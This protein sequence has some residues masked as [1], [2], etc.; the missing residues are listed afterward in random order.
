[1]SSNLLAQDNSVLL[2]IDV[3]SKL[4]GAMSPE[5]RQAVTCYSAILAEAANLLNIPVLV[6]EQYPKGLGTTD[7][8]ITAKLPQTA[9]T[10]TKT[11]FS[12]C[13]AIGFKQALSSGQRQQIILT[14]MEA[15]ICV[16]QTALDLHQQGYQISVV[17][18]PYVLAIQN[19][20][21][22]PCNAYNTKA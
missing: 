13:Q 15:H 3:Q 22:M 4:L 7:S 11:S 12:C 17:A 1:M 10:F 8:V 20:N 9:E 6:T 14:G 18:E 16:L 19:I 5:Q 2:I 21:F